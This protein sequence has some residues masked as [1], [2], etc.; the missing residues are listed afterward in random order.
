VTKTVETVRAEQGAHAKAGLLARLQAKKPLTATYELVLD[1]EVWGR[2]EAARDAV[3]RARLFDDAGLA[4]AQTALE[5]AEADAETAG[6]VERLHLQA[7]ARPVYESL[8]LANPPTEEQKAE[9][10][11]YN[12]DTFSPALVAAAL[13][14]PETGE[15]P[16]TA[17]DVAALWTSWNQGEVYALWSAALQ[18]STSVRNPAVPFGSARTR[19]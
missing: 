6:A 2:V 14:D 7:V 1:P 18:V 17:E 5:Q 4:A 16:L 13:V 19:G 11:T 10:Q 3:E 9:G 8:L 15:H 12:V